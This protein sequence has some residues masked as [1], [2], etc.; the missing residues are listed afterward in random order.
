M[1]NIVIT[2]ADGNLGGRLVKR[3]ADSTEYG[4]IAVGL[5]REALENMLEREQIVRRDKIRLMQTDDF[6]A[7][8]LKAMDAA[9]AVH[10]AFA[11]AIFPNKDIASSLDF[12]L[13]AFRKIALSGVPN[14]VY[15]SSQSVYGDEQA[16]REVGMSPAPGS[17]YAMAKYAGEKLF[18]SVYLNTPELQHTIIRLDLVAQSQRL[19]IGLCK[20]ALTDHQINLKGGKQLFS[21]IDADDVPAALTALLLTDKPWKPIYNVGFH[22]QRYT[23]T[24]IAE[25]VREVA[26]EH[27]NPDVRI[28]LTENDTE[29]YAGMDT[30]AFMED[31]GW[32]PEYPIREI[33]SR[34]YTSLS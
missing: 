26:A 10:L 7:A 19:I 3:L 27:G 11:R 5:I 16:F 30:K 15:V 9:G 2:G 25:I 29:L 17:V 32:K 21:Y 22:C 14:A 24:E 28:E 20:A 13:A 6:F 8:D 12:S 1:K 4:V 18:E 34:I 33:V 23:L 31:T